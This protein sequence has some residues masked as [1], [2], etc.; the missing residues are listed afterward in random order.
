MS[1]EPISFDTLG[2]RAPGSAG[3]GTSPRR[4]PEPGREAPW[5]AAGRP[6]APTHCGPKCWS[7]GRGDDPAGGGGPGQLRAGADRSARRPIARAAERM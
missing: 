4:A 6:N 7:W 1:E 2:P 5:R 3:R